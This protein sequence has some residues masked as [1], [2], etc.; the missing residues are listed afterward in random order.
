VWNK[1][2]RG[3]VEGGIRMEGEL[4]GVEKR[5]A[6]YCC[7]GRITGGELPGLNKDRRGYAWGVKS[8]DLAGQLLCPKMFYCC[9]ILILICS[10]NKK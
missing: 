7:G 6:G 10:R 8:W 1:D 5:W 3:I 4:S 2:D 9:F